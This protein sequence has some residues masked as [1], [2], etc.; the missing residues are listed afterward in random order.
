MLGGIRAQGSRE[1]YRFTGSGFV[2]VRS[3]DQPFSM[4]FCQRYVKNKFSGSGFRV[5]LP[6]MFEDLAG[7]SLLAIEDPT[8][9]CLLLGGALG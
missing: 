2:T 8:D 3:L 6:S 4:G 5:S 7:I 9:V 1:V